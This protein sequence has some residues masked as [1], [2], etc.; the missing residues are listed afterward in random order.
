MSDTHINAFFADRDEALVKV[1]AAQAE[2]DVASK[3]LEAKKKEIG[4]KEPQTKTQSTPVQTST[5]PEVEDKNK[6]KK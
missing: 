3:R 1:Q 4:W 2:Y 5:T 6:K